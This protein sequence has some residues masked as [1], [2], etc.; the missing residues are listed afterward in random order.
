MGGGAVA[1]GVVDNGG[2]VECYGDDVHVCA[3]VGV[4][5]GCVGVGADSRPGANEAGRAGLGLGL[6]LERGR[7][8]RE[9]DE[10]RFKGRV[11]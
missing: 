2:G 11:D 10:K 9:K 6:G 8:L 7:G 4:V 1:D 5:G 3:C